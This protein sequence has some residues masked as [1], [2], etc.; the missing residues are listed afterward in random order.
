MTTEAAIANTTMEGSG[1]Y[2]RNS[3]LQAAGIELA[4]P[5]FEEAARTIPIDG[6]AHTPIVIADYGSSQGRNSMRPIGLGIDT[7]RARVGP[8][9]PIEVIHTDLPSND[10][11]SLFTALNE[12]PAG[13]LANRPGVFPYAVGRSYFDPILPPGRVHLGWNTWTLHWL[14]RNPMEVSDHLMA[15]LSPSQ[16]ARELARHQS[17][18]DWARFLAAR[19]TEMAVDAQ[20][21]SLAIGATDEVHGW[22]WILGELWLAALDMAGDGLLTPLELSR[23][24][25]PVVGRTI[26]DLRAPFAQGAF[27]GLSL[28]YAD[29]REGPDPFWEEFQTT[30]DAEGLGKR[31][32]GMLRAVCGPIASMAFAARPS[33]D[34]LV[35]ELFGRLESRVAASP[36]RQ[37]HFVAIAVVRKKAVG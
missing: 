22:D 33:S 21:V 19:A 31:W 28:D 10:F 11:A 14:S 16:K 9:R 7:L 30:G 32:A 26:A 2:N 24:T 27:C 13:Y 15:A 17:G 37:Q 29:V 3:D 18:E 35:N 5:L 20:L 34:A 8:D 12:E 25:T 4:L 6:G 23:F 1:F 36:K